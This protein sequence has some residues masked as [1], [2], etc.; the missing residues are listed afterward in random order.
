MRKLVAQIKLLYWRF[1]PKATWPRQ[2]PASAYQF[3]KEQLDILEFQK[4]PKAYKAKLLKSNN[5][6]RSEG[7]F[8]EAPSGKDG[9]DMLNSADVGA[10]PP[11]KIGSFVDAVF[12]D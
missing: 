11:E 9:L 10:S 6:N 5:N 7:T 2:S 1:N 12:P 4:D 8:E 3:A